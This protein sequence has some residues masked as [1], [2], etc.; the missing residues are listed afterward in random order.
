MLRICKRS[1]KLK[2]FSELKKMPSELKEIENNKENTKII[3]IDFF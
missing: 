3:N 1:P 2:K